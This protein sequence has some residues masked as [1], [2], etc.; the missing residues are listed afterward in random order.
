M[1]LDAVVKRHLTILSDL[2]AR[3]ERGI[4]QILCAYV[5]DAAQQGIVKLGD[6]KEIYDTYMNAY[7]S[8][9]NNE[10]GDLYKTQVRL[11][12]HCI[13]DGIDANHTD[14]E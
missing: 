8:S 10:Q 12:K 3:G 1:A 14:G 9:L 6:E 11:M 4:Y 7:I 2:Y 13:E 5:R